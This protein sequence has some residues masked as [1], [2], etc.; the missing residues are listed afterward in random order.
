M[1]QDRYEALGG[2]RVLNEAQSKLGK[3]QQDLNQN[4]PV[5]SIV[6]PRTNNLL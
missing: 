2:D 1:W 4:E 3:M 5:K 6:N